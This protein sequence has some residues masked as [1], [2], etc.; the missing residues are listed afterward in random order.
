MQL[1]RCH[2]RYMI[3]R[4]HHRR[5]IIT[6]ITQDLRASNAALP[7]RWCG[8]IECSFHLR[9]RLAGTL[10]LAKSVNLNLLPLCL[11]PLPL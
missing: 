10:L 4:V 9:Q 2:L 6:I 11:L 8:T 3:H 5:C 1:T 7:I